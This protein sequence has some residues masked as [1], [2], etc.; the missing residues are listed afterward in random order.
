MQY[1]QIESKKDSR[2]TQRIID[3]MEKNSEKNI[4]FLNQVH[5]DNSVFL[6]MIFER[7]DKPLDD[8]K[9]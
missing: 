7:V 2:E 9:S 8:T 6:R 4:A 3:R 1:M 5:K